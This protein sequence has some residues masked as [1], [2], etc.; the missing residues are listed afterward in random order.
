MSVPWARTIRILKSEIPG[1]T[2][3]ALI[4]DF[5]ANPELVGMVID[6]SPEVISHNLETV[7]RLTP[8]IRSR[9]R[10]ALCPSFMWQVSGS[11]PSLS[12]TRVPPIPRRI[13]WQRRISMSPP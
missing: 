13:S 2:V 7:E 12:S 6:A 11:I 5:D 1:L 3:E 4:P 9:A 8:R 10:K